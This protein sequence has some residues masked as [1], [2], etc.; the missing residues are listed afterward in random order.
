M[1]SH[2]T[3]KNEHANGRNG[4]STKKAHWSGG[5]SAHE[6]L[7]KHKHL[8][9]ELVISRWESSIFLRRING[10]EL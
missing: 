2:S 7:S 5:L 3:C 10:Q 6:A 1:A 4:M 9:T 8:V